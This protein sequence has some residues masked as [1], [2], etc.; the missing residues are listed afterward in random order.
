MDTSPTYAVV[1]ENQQ[2]K[3]EDFDML[4]NT[5]MTSAGR[6]KL[7]TDFNAQSIQTSA[8]KHS[9]QRGFSLTHADQEGKTSISGI[10]DPLEVTEEPQ[11]WNLEPDLEIPYQAKIASIPLS[12]FPSKLQQL[13]SAAAKNV[14][15]VWQATGT[16]S[17]IYVW[18]LI[19]LE[20]ASNFWN[21]FSKSLI[22]SSQNFPRHYS[23]PDITE[24]VKCSQITPEKQEPAR[25]TARSY[26]LIVKSSNTAVSEIL[27]SL[28]TMKNKDY[29]DMLPLSS[30]SSIEEQ[31]EIPLFNGNALMIYNRQVYL[32]YVMRHE[33]LTAE[34]EMVWY[35]PMLLVKTMVWLI[36]CGSIHNLPFKVP[37]PLLPRENAVKQNIKCL[38]TCATPIHQDKTSNETHSSSHEMTTI[39]QP[40]NCSP[41]TAKMHQ[42]LNETVSPSKES[43]E[44]RN[45]EE[46]PEDKD[47]ELRKK[48]GIV[49]DVRVNLTRLSPSELKK[50]SGK[51][52]A[53]KRKV[54][55]RAKN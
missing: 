13:L 22:P 14:S 37:H 43:L 6:G 44:K 32:L 8:E 50:Y 53:H 19:K 45:E 9:L 5:G 52:P 11:A 29:K 21:N 47:K 3:S 48:S 55:T 25:K 31:V 16:E 26:P 23:S 41:S 39:S 30:I 4:E 54:T 27:K 46:A 33:D 1:L 38:T 18:P 15:E 17:V 40:K 2:L 49:K 36:T 12:S 34:R 51:P 35:H 28:I 7:S 42:F 24:D 10:S 20:E